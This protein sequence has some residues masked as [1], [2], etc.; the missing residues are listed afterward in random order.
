[1][2]F[3]LQLTVLFAFVFLHSLNAFAQNKFEGYNIIVDAPDTQRTATCAIRYV[4]PTTDITITDLDA[5]TPMKISNCGGTGS[6][7]TQTGTTAV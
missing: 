5:S 2:K 7:L 4:P 3:F 1:M 6:S